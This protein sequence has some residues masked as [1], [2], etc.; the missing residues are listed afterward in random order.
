MTEHRRKQLE[1]NLVRILN[2]LEAHYAAEQVI[3]FG[4][5]ASGNITDTSDLD[6][7]IVRNT[8]KR[9]FDRIRDVVKICD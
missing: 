3:L 6:L 8:D 4:S 5:L 9:F 1:E 7:L 2:A